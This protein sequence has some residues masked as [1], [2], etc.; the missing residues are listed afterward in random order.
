MTALSKIIIHFFFIKST[1]QQEIEV[2][3]NYVLIN[4]KLN[5]V[6]GENWV[7]ALFKDLGIK[8]YFFIF[9]KLTLYFSY[10][11]IFLLVLLPLSIVSQNIFKTPRQ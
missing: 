1:I 9:I 5:R 10:I 6:L 4:Y 8:V 7:I 11:N 3:L 2:L